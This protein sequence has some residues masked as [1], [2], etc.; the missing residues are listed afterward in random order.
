M[1]LNLEKS[2]IKAPLPLCSNIRELEKRSTLPCGGR[3]FKIFQ[4]HLRTQCRDTLENF[5]PNS[6]RRG[7]M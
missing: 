6:T 2:A 5:V 7:C 4:L 3:S 1:Q